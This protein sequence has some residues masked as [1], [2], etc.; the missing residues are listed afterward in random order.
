MFWVYFSQV[1]GS[2]FEGVD[3]S[4]QWLHNFNGHAAVVENLSTTLV[5]RSSFNF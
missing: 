2:V 4:A 1:N 5:E 3:L